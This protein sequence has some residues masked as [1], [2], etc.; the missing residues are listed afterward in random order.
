[1]AK[2]F[3]RHRLGFTDYSAYDRAFKSLQTHHKLET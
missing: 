3:L 1:M 2:F